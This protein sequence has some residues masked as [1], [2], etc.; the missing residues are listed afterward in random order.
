MQRL[1][2]PG[3]P[4]LAHLGN[5]P[6]DEL[7]VADLRE[8]WSAAIDRPGRSTK[9][10]RTYLDALAAVLGYA[11]DLDLCDGSSVDGFRRI[12]K[13]WSRTQR[14]RAESDPSRTI[15]AIEDAAEITR[16][17]RAASE[18]RPI[19]RL[20]VLLCLDAGLRRGEAIALRWRSVIWG[21][22]E[23]DTRRALVICESRPRGGR[24]GLTKTGR[25]R[26]VDL[27]RRLRRTLWTE[28]RRVIGRGED[29][30]ALGAIDPDNFNSR[31]W[32][33]IVMRADIG[34]VQ[35]K[36]L[37]DTCASHLLSGGVPLAYVSNQ[38]GHTA[39]G[40]T[41]RHYAKW[42]ERE[43]YRPSIALKPGEVPADILAR[44][45]TELRWHSHNGSSPRVNLR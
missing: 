18:E 6:V 27:S 24:P 16:L 30:F 28:F 1:L 3:G 26:R 5:R 13:R 33:R 9:T 19:P 11:A 42:I 34:P 14:G 7:R 2:R 45:S 36:D 17:L 32:R 39:I 4:I 31:E 29:D 23:D 8:W 35:L 21:D 41:E 20:L 38:L 12:L 10:G 25:Q 44:L 43:E 15:R 22:S 37:R 40:T